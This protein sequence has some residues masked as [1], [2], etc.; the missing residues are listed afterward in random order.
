MNG[1]AQGS[2]PRNLNFFQQVFDDRKLGQRSLLI[3][4]NLP[5]PS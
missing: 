4:S 1:A 2:I 3:A 5:H